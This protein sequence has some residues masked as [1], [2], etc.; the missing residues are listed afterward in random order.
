MFVWF[1]ARH[2]HTLFGQTIV[3]VTSVAYLLEDGCS[4]PLPWSDMLGVV[5]DTAA[6]TA[7]TQRRSGGADSRP[8][9]RNGRE[10][11]TFAV[12]ASRCLS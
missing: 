6:R 8:S 3:Y 5:G 4:S 11:S 9:A 2:A 12:V 7:Y 1:V 10:G